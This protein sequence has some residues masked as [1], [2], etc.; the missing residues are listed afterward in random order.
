MNSAGTLPTLFSSGWKRNE[1][2]EKTGEF[3]FAFGLNRRE[4]ERGGGVTRRGEILFHLIFL[5]ETQWALSRVS[6]GKTAPNRWRQP[7]ALPPPPLINSLPFSFASLQLSRHHDAS[8]AS[9]PV[10]LITIFLP[11]LRNAANHRLFFLFAIEILFTSFFLSLFIS[12]PPRIFL[13]SSSPATSCLILAIR[14]REVLANRNSFYSGS[15]F[16]STLSRI[17]AF[18]RFSF[19]FPS[20]SR[21][22]SLLPEHSRSSYNVSREISRIIHKCFLSI[23]LATYFECV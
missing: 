14:Q 19:A 10:N 21:P 12:T 11:P 23:A 17:I 6:E 3:P 5:H 16:T 15:L 8:D 7:E 13:Y 20:L 2:E 4:R 22:F 18:R 1:R 9:G